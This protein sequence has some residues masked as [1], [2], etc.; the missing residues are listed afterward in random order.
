[1]L[2]D[3]VPMLSVLHAE[4]P[5]ADIQSQMMLY[6]QFVGSWEGRVVVHA[7][8]GS[9]G[10]AGC[11]VHFGWV[12]EGRAV[13]DVWIAPSRSERQGSKIPAR[14]ALYGT[15]L[16]VYDPQSDL[17]HILWINPVTQAYDSMLGRKAGADIV[18]E[19]RKEDGTQCQWCFTEVTANSFHW[20][21]RESKDDGKSWRILTEFFMK[22]TAPD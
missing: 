14:G 3:Q 1:M 12:L 18:Q 10:E 4:G 13:Q 8:D 11:E 17:W 9:R 7:P 19:Y 20:L 6:G 2:K 15:T 5:A 22:R 16:R 21:S